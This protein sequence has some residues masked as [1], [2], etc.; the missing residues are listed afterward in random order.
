[1]IEQPQAFIAQDTLD[2][3]QHLVFDESVGE[4]QERYVDLRVFALQNGNGEVTVFPGG[5]TRVS[6]P[7]SRITNNSSGGSCK[8]SWVVV[9][10]EAVPVHYAYVARYEY[11]DVVVQNDNFLMVSACTDRYQTAGPCDAQTTPPGR[12]VKF[13][14]RMGNLVHRVRVTVPHQE[15]IIAAVGQASLDRAAVSVPDSPLTPG[16]FSPQLEEFLTPS[17]LVDPAGVAHAAQE[18]CRDATTL[19]E[20]INSVVLWV[21][22]EIEYQRGN[23]SVSTAAADVLIS[24]RGVCQDKT[25]LALGMI[26]SLG[27]PCRYVSGLLT[28]QAGETHAWLE[29]MHPEVGWLLA[30]PTRRIVAATDI[31]HLKFGVGR[32]YSEVPPVTGSFVSTGPGYLDI[33]RAY[34]YFDR[35]DVSFDDALLLIE[36]YRRWMRAADRW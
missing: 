33:A 18:V 15:L 14:D 20:S 17:P 5:L 21:K 11:A 26:R 3:S 28:R 30:D 10:G 34:V 12:K 23:T 27:I 16:V 8:P 29:F 35:N 19:L 6:E 13:T 22:D 25:H 7:S 4:L 31:D 32:D 1:M 9:I 2:F 36:P 24:R